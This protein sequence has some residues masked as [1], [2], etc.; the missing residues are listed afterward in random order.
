MDL[1]NLSIVRQFFANTVFTHKTQEVAAEFL[2]NNALKVKLANLV[3]TILVFITFILQLI[4]RYYFI[5]YLGILLSVVEFMF[6]IFHLSFKF[7]EKATIHKNSALKY[8]N[9]RNAYTSLITDIMNGHTPVKE[10]RSK[11]D[12]LLREYQILC[13]LAPQTGRPEY[14]ESQ[15]RL[16][17]RGV[18]EGEDFTWSDEEIDRFLPKE[19]RIKNGKIIKKEVRKN[20]K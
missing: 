1:K 3:L 18:I 20:E 19:L 17:K 15:K 2:E 12:D 10:I 5:S 6:L 8:L 9:L 11:R 14:T 7:E 13:D 4:Y 16:N